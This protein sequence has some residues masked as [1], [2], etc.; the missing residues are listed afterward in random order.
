MD[1]IISNFMDITQSLQDLHLEIPTNI[2]DEIVSNINKDIDL[3]VDY[4]YLIFER[5]ELIRVMNLTN[6]LIQ[7][8]SDNYS[9]NSI[10][11]VP[12]LLHKRIYFYATNELSHFRY[13]SELLGEES[14]MLNENISIPLQILQKLVK[15]MG[16]KVLIYKKDNNY[17][18]RL[19]DG[20]LLLDARRA[21][22]KIIFFPGEVDIFSDD[23]RLGELR[24]NEFG[25]I[26]NSIV[27][28]LNS[29]VKGDLKKI[30]FTGDKAYYN[31]S[32]YYIEALINT[33]VISLSLRDADLINK[34]YKYYKNETMILYKV[35]SSVPRLFLKLNN[36]E[37]QFINS[38]SSV[39]N[40]MTQQM[41]ELIKPIEVLIDFDRLNRIVTL[42][43]SL[44]SSTGN[45]E[46]SY[47]ED[48][49]IINLSS[50]NGNSEFKI[51]IVKQTDIL[52]ND[53]VL[54]KAETLKRLL[55]S[56]S[57]TEKIGISLNN[58][59][60][61]IEYRNIKSIMMTIN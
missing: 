47:N 51:P 30:S 13:Y 49:M 12:V 28:L 35:K 41:S 20:D 17:Y 9:Y 31:S 43:T 32:F 6:K 23:G 48:N 27:P 33:P 1:E 55:T 4:P 44:P 39:S 7:Y 22:D 40:L 14:E 11:L 38:N 46:L 25:K 53:K 50:M 21:D 42:S 61:N 26:I 3:R 58:N 56:F 18:I 57:N 2:D 15:L 19:L 54:I 5:D 59:S 52:F 29:E 37:Y 16:N 10:S 34:L 24:M 8:K 36:I 45:I 60:I